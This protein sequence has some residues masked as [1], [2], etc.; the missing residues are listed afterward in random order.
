MNTAPGTDHVTFMAM[1]DVSNVKFGWESYSIGDMRFG[2]MASP[3]EPAGLAAAHKKEVCP[4]MMMKY[5]K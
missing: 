5:T 3:L 4:N 2:S 1:K